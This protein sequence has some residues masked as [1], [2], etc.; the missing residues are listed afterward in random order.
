MDN[1]FKKHHGM[2]FLIQRNFKLRF[3]G[4]IKP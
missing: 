1:I 2:R 3:E 4:I